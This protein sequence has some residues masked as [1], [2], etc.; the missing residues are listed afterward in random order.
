MRIR[1]QESGATAGEVEM[2][3]QLHCDEGDHGSSENEEHEEHLLPVK[4]LSLHLPSVLSIQLARGQTAQRTV[5]LGGKAAV[6]SAAGAVA[7]RLG[8]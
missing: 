2:K 1:R 5:R 8:L 6:R 7:I 3:D 4:S